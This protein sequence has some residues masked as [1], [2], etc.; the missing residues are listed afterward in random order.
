MTKKILSLALMSLLVLLTASAQ[1]RG[2]VN[3]NNAVDVADVNQ[4]ISEL[5]KGISP[6]W[7]EDMNGDGIADVIDI[8]MVI[9]VI[10]GK[11]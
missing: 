5:L 7:Y 4:L 11:R 9:N 2:D 1:K 10:L 3:G 6:V 8:N